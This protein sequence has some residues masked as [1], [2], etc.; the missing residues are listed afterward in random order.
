MRQ[1]FFIPA[2]FLFAFASCKKNLNGISEN[3][4]TESS[5]VAGRSQLNF[6][7]HNLVIKSETGSS[8]K[9]TFSYSISAGKI[10]LT[11]TWTDEYSTQQFDFEK[12]DDNTIRIENLY[13][14][15]PEDSKTY[16]IFKK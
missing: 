6:I 3:L 15:V 16:M 12:V 2:L 10:Q 9:D 13:P 8:Y 4:Y 1:M 7:N 5:P 14:A 11:P